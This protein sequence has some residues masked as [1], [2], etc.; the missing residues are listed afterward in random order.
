V[1]GLFFQHERAVLPAETPYQIHFS[2]PPINPLSPLFEALDGATNRGLHPGVFDYRYAT[3]S[4]I[5]G[6][7]LWGLLLW[8]RIIL[9]VVH[10]DPRMPM[11]IQAEAADVI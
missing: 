10:H 8:D 11:G 9:L 5:D 7:Y 3:F 1:R 2:I 4:E 6:M